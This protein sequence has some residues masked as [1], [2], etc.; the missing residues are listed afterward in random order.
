MQQRLAAFT[1]C[2]CWYDDGQTVGLMLCGHRHCCGATCRIL[3]SST[4]KHNLSGVSDAKPCL[5]VSARNSHGSD[6]Q[7]KPC[8]AVRVST[9]NMLRPTMSALA[10]STQHSYARLREAV[11]RRAHKCADRGERVSSERCGWYLCSPITR[12]SITCSS[13]SLPDAWSQLPSAINQ[14][15]QEDPPEVSIVPAQRF[16]ADACV[17]GR[18]GF[19]RHELRRGTVVSPAAPV[20][21]ADEFPQVPD[22]CLFL[23]LDASQLCTAVRCL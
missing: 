3:T 18:G 11:S 8:T 17:I 9:I 4:K 15:V 21:D 10:A 19:D 12:S 23:T 13:C 6:G 16:S 7:R 14:S 22:G 20:S 2:A 1:A 5:A